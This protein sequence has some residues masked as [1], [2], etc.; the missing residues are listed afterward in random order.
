[1]LDEIARGD[2]AQPL[3]LPTIGGQRNAAA[4]QSFQFE[5]LED[6]NESKPLTKRSA[7]DV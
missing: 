4:N 3:R 6:E 7:T 1:M 5:D 2:P